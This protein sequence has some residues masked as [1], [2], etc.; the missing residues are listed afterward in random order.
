MRSPTPFVLTLLALFAF[1]C[2]STGSADHQARFTRDGAYML[3]AGMTPS[4][5]IARFGTPDRQEVRRIGDSTSAVSW[6]GLVL[7]YQVEKQLERSA[8][9][10]NELVFDRSYDPPRL[11]YWMLSSLQYRDGGN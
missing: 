5:V 3:R 4:E 9:P 10:E 6:E 1:G 2:A 11:N 8:L 7:V